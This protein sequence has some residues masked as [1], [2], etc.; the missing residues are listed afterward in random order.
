MPLPVVVLAAVGAVSAVGAVIARQWHDSRD[1]VVLGQRAVGKTRLVN[2]WL[3]DWSTPEPT[4]SPSGF[5]KITLSVEDREQAPPREILLDTVTDVS[6]GDQGLHTVAAEL[7]RASAVLY[8]LRADTLLTEERRAPGE[9]QG[10]DWERAQLDAARIG[11]RA[12]AAKRVVFVVTHTDLDPR[13]A[14]TGSQDYLDLVFGQLSDLR[15]AAG[16]PD[17]VRVVAGSLV[18][19]A[20]ATA[21][22]GEII[23]NLR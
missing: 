1:V 15:T 18:D 10:E 16:A 13:C 21:L 14:R 4:R 23:E 22:T 17:G 12:T 5:T 11:G 9:E 6:G 20:S 2:S 19:Q 3:G 8:L 7:G